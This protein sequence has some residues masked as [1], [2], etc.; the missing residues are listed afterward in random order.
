MKNDLLL[1]EGINIRRLYDEKTETWFFFR[2]GYHASIIAA[3]RL[4]GCQ[5]LLESP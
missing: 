5:K 4:S 2:G 3:A 1:F